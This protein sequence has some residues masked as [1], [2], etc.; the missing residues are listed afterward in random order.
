MRSADFDDPEVL[1]EVRAEF[2]RYEAA[3]VSNDREALVEF[4]LDSPTTIRYGID[5][6][7][8]GH[9]ELAAFRRSQAVATPPRDLQRTV[10]TAFGRD[11]AV[12]NTEFV[13]HGTSVTGRQSQV[14]VRTDAG[15]KVASAHVSWLGGRGPA[16]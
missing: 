16:S 11:V 5:D 8:Y 12:A 14:W 1:A 3:L 7:Q 10:V 4:F 2:D 9:A 15:W 13:P 6:A